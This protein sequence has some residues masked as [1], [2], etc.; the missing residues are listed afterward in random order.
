MDWCRGCS[1][2]ATDAD[3]FPATT[4]PHCFL[5]KDGVLIPISPRSERGRPQPLQPLQPLHRRTADVEEPTV[6]GDSSTSAET[7]PSLPL[8]PQIVCDPAY[9]LGE[10][11]R[12]SLRTLRYALPTNSASEAELCACVHVCMCG[13]YLDSCEFIDSP[14]AH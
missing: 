8:F 4:K 12:Q 10:S 11:N 6:D 5:W 3:D 1:H 13:W 14:R 9:R 7:P 2:R